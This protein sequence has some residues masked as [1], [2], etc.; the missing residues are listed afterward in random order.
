MQGMT[1]EQ[2]A[3]ELQR[4]DDA[5]RDFKVPSEHLTLEVESGGTAG[6]P[7]MNWEAGSEKFSS[8]MTN[9]AK[10]QLAART[11]IPKKL[12]DRLLGNPSYYGNLEL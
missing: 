12:M 5:K 8:V 3:M 11:G 1:I 9:H 7:I 10:G 2:F 4:R 6:V